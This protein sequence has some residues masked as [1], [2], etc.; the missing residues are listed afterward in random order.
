MT[1]GTLTDII[2]KFENYPSKMKIKE[3]I[4]KNNKSP[5]SLVTSEEVE[6]EIN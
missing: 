1:D 3:N 5:F 4:N 2:R 6:K